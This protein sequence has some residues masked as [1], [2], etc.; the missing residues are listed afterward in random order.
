M[1]ISPA[2]LIYEVKCGLM[3]GHLPT[4]GAGTAIQQLRNLALRFSTGQQPLNLSSF[5]IRQLVACRST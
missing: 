1:P 2:S 4:D 5:A 3:I